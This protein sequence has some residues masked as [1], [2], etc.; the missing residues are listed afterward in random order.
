ML[1]RRCFL[2]GLAGLVLAEWP[3]F[4]APKA[5]LGEDGLYHLDWYLS[6]F[7]ELAEDRSGAH[8]KG[9]RLAILWGLK[10]CPACRQLHDVHLADPAI[11]AYLKANFEI[12]HLD[13][14]G[15]R[16]VT[17]FDGSKLTEKA[18]AARYGIRSTPAF[19]FFPETPDGLAV[20]A[21]DKREVARLTTLPEPSRFLP[22]FRYVRE[23]GYDAETFGDWLRRQPS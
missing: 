18:L 20:R 3:V 21:P 19:Q 23:K 7:L 17:D 14:I 12:L 16:T 10:G 9:K 5:R 15:A 11:E 8:D 1:D 22:V 13:I 6:S 4:A 2:T